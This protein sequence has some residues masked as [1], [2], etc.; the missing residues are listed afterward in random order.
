[1]LFEQTTMTL[2]NSSVIA[3]DTGTSVSK[4]KQDRQFSLLYRACC[5]VTQLLYQPLHIYK[6]YTLK[7]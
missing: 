6:I 2:L 4:I 5:R 3:V 7:H 1:M